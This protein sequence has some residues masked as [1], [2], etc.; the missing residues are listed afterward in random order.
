MHILRRLDGER[1]QSDI[2][3]KLGCGSEQEINLKLLIASPESSAFWPVSQDETFVVFKDRSPGA[4]IHWLCVP[5]DHI[6]EH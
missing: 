4:R 1:L 6:C 2:R 5:R 3:G